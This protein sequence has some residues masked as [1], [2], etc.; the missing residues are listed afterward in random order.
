MGYGKPPNLIDIFITTSRFVQ[1]RIR[2]CYARDSEIIYPP[3]HTDFFTPSPL[4][5]R[6]EFYLVS[7][8]L[9]PYKRNDTVIEGFNQLGRGLG[10]VGDGPELNRLREIA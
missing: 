5:R 8:A 7:G 3:V 9:V 1:E 4:C 6:E 10:V 2:S